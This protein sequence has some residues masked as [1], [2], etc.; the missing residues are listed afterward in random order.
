MSRVTFRKGLTPNSP[1]NGEVTLFVGNDGIL[2]S[3][4]ENGV[5]TPLSAVEVLNQLEQ[6]IIDRQTADAA[7]EA[8]IIAE[9]TARQAADTVLQGMIEDEITNRQDADTAIQASVDSEVVAR[10][11]ATNNIQANIDAEVTAR[12]ASDAAISAQFNAINVDN[13]FSVAKILKVKKNPGAGEYSTIAAAVA[14]ATTAIDRNEDNHYVIE[15]GPGLYQET[16]LIIPSFCHI[17][18]STIESTIVEPIGAHNVFSLNFKCE[19]SF[20]TIQNAPVG[21]AG[22]ACIN[23]GDYTQMH[24]VSMYNNDTHI[25]VEASTQ[26]CIMYLEYVD[27]NGVYNKGLHVRTANGYG[28]DVNVENFYSFADLTAGDMIFAEGAGASL[29]VL[30]CGFEGNGLNRG[31]VAS[32]GAYIATRS[33]YIKNCLTAIQSEN[34][35]LAPTLIMSSTGFVN[36]ATN[37]KISH[38]GT[39]GN[40][41]GYTLYE[42][43][44]LIKDAPFFIANKDAHIITVAKK[45]GDFNNIADALASITDNTYDNPYVISVGPGVFSSSETLVMKEE[46]IV[47]GSGRT[48]IE[49]SDPT[50]DVIQAVQNSSIQK[51]DVKGAKLACGVNFNGIGMGGPFTIDNC[52]FTDNNIHVRAASPTAGIIILINTQFDGGTPYTRCLH[53]EGSAPAVN[54]IIGNALALI[55]VTPPFGEDFALAQGTGA[56]IVVA[57][58]LLNGGAV[59]HSAFEVL[60]G[61]QLNLNSVII[62]GFNKG[63]NTVNAGVGPNIQVLACQFTDC[64]TDIEIAHPGTTGSLN[65]SANRDKISINSDSNISTLISD[66]HNGG[67]MS[68]GELYLGRNWENLNPVL[69]LI[70]SG[71]PMGVMEGGLLSTSSGLT[72]DVSPGFGYLMIGSH[73]NHFLRRYNWAGSSLSIPPN[74]NHYIYVNASGILTQSG[75]IPSMTGTILLGRVVSGPLTIDFIDS[76]PADAHHLANKLDRFTRNA[77]GSI[78]ESGS[79]V[80]EVGTRGLAVTGGVY[81]FSSVRYITTG[82]SP[83]TFQTHYRDGVSDFIRASSSQVSNSQWDNGTGALATIDLDKYVKHSLYVVGSGANE[84]YLLV[85]GQTQFNSL[86]E[87]EQGPIPLAPSWF[88]ESV[89]LIASMV[90]EGDGT[91]N[92]TTYPNIIQIRDERPVI[93]F[94]SSGVSATSTHSNLLGLEQDD[95]HQY[96]R[97]DGGRVMSGNIAMGGNSITNINLINGVDITVHASRHLPNG[98]DP[99]TT[100]VP[101]TVGSVN[102]E[103]IANAFSRQ[104]HV[105]A[106]GN[107]AGGSTHAAVTATENGYMSAADKVKLDTIAN[108][109]TANATDAELRNRQTHT[110]TQTASTISDFDIA[111]DA[112]ITLK[113]GAANG[114]AALDA[115]TKVPIAQLPTAAP[116]TQGPDAVNAE[117]TS[118]AVARADHVHNIPAAAPVNTGTANTEG[119]SASFARADHI[120]NT[121]I[122]NT[123]VTGTTATT[124]N[125]TTDVL[126]PGMTMTPAA[127]TYL[128]R[129]SLCGGHTANNTVSRFSI[130][131]AGAQVAHSE[132]TVSASNGVFTVDT[133]AIVTVNG[134]QTIDARFRTVS[135]TLTANQRS[136]IIVKLG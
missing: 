54:Q 8:L 85:Y 57:S 118:L 19:L 10:Q 87:A 73:P 2:R 59:T 20:I 32:N 47:I 46:V 13:R 30:S 108:G 3:I 50:K 109:A 45:G 104:D 29:F 44:D 86:V 69:D 12:L 114:V 7:I 94:K 125:S 132:R 14:Y 80:T 5:V 63:V 103:G 53:A 23:S 82:G 67:I 105:H 91:T 129:F 98:A 127:G 119:T 61:A 112:R 106:H 89:T 90:V 116:I 55:D 40:Y 68:A 16:E 34:S 101:S 136:L 131:S 22:V 38:P 49:I 72:L 81:H 9:A 133:Q 60:D 84:K 48:I 113:R 28:A 122:A 120:H 6:E 11:I 25:L 71:A 43:L 58:S 37:I 33:V 4:D 121:I 65:C 56:K 74:S 100:G 124:T 135:G 134:A 70:E 27:I 126:I 31:I 15:V 77:L 64:I 75:A 18:G 110:G 41:V 35:G 102:T 117:G 107:L 92:N 79:L 66:I 83:I 97:A 123:S 52:Y 99:L 93:G 24:K 1:T 42:K 26:D 115:S 95:H 130:Y 21:F 51:V 96:F 78:Y 111:T 76:A 88:N 36:C 39:I 17:K 128:V 62:S